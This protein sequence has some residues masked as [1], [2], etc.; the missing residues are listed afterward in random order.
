MSLI[1]YKKVGFLMVSVPLLLF[2]YKGSAQAFSTIELNKPAKYENR[3]L[4]AENTPLTKISRTKK[5]YQN[6]VSHY[7]YYFNANK[8][9]V[10]ILEKGKE[11]FKEDYTTLLPFYNYTIKDLS[12][13]RT[14]LDSVIYKC[15]AGI[16]LHDL[17]SDWVDDLYLLMGQ[18]FLFRNDFDSATQVFK[19]INYAFSPKDENYDIPIGSN[20]S[21]NNGIF[22]IVTK[23]S[24]SVWKKLTTEPPSRNESFLWQIRTYLEQD[25]LSEA[26]GLIQL[27]RADPNFPKRLVASLHE[28]T[29]FAFYKEQSTDSAAWHLNKA[30]EQSINRQEKARWQFLIGQLYS[31]SKKDSLAVHAYQLAINNTTDPTLEVYAHLAISALE[32]GHKKNAVEENLNELLKMGKRPLFEGYKDIIYYAAAKLAIQ[33]NKIKAAQTYLTK[34]L[35]S[36]ASNSIQRE[37]SFLLLADLNYDKKNYTDAY[38]FYD[39]LQIAQLKEL[40][41]NKV[42][43]RKPGLKIITENMAVITREDSLQKLA[44]MPVEERNTAIKN[45]LKQ[46]RKLAGLKEQENQDPSFGGGNLMGNS[47]Q[48]TDLFSTANNEFYFQN[49]SLKQN[50]FI[51][52]KSKWGTRP[53]IDNWRRQSAIEKSF[54]KSNP[55]AIAVATPLVDKNATA[56]TAVVAEELSFESLERKLP[57]SSEKMSASYVLILNAL[58]ANGSVFQNQITDYPSAIEVYKTIIQR[59]PD[60]SETEKSLFNLANCYD[61][62]DQPIQADSV[63]G[64]LSKNFVGGVYTKQLAKASAN[65]KT[66][67]ASDTYIKIYNLFVAGDFN[68]AFAAKQQ[69]DKL[70]GKT[71]WTPQ[72][73]FIESIYYVKQ[74]NDSTAI[75]TLH[76]LIQLFPKSIMATKATTMIEVLNKRKEIETYLTNLSIEKTDEPITRAVDLNN[77]SAEKNITSA[78]PIG[79]NKSVQSEMKVGGKLEALGLAPNK[80]NGYVF[81]AADSQWVVVVL[82]KVDAIFASEGKNAFNRFNRETGSSENIALN[83]MALNAQY[84]FIMMGP[85]INAAVAMDYI[86][87]TKP[88]AKSRI[89]PWLSAEKYSFTMISNKNLT[90]LK[91]TKDIAAYEK[92]IREIFPDVF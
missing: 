49:T 4:P 15:T 82:D 75:N 65:K 42:E 27:L 1:K 5:F 61:R 18:A 8:K 28:M 64:L 67:P 80:T 30:L 3:T 10:E 52:F 21:N 32:A 26:E 76:Q 83:A 87:K 14:Q 70:F 68:E 63:R 2:Q 79:I 19:Y 90:I 6:T 47:I 7:N 46:L 59:F 11:R 60:I 50:G 53:N 43:S 29:A 86:G 44:L 25:K 16:V 38:R 41:K 56:G 84:Q 37:M 85:F 58:L 72:Q 91:E 45:K 9:I 55:T 69:A 17:R 34:S 73:L 22:S 48:T 62:N 12:E 35:Q 88:F 36:S 66:D 77:S 51:E 92:F 57:L 23:E 13:D 31:L 78:A 74:R 89:I 33:Q 71:Y 40:D 54:A 24:K 81:N 39:S 20:A